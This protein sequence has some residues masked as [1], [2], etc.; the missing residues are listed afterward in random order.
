MSRQ[1]IEHNPVAPRSPK[2][3]D[4]YHLRIRKP[5][6]FQK[7]QRCHFG[8][9]AVPDVVTEICFSRTPLSQNEPQSGTQQVARSPRR[10]PAEDFGHLPAISASRS[11][12][13]NRLAREN[14][15]RVPQQIWA[16]LPRETDFVLARG[17]HPKNPMTAALGCTGKRAS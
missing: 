13:V 14:N 3:C 11:R 8:L 7:Y 4:P 16:S 1:I 10:Q 12:N 9:R 17:S 6:A 15:F 2:M 5:V